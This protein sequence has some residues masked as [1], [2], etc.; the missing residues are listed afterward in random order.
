MARLI[1]NDR[2]LV[3]P[4][5][6]CRPP[7]QSESAVFYDS[8]RAAVF[9]LA[10]ALGLDK[11]ASVLLPA[12]VPEGLIAP[13]NRAGIRV[14]QYAVDRNLD[15][16][17]SHLE[18][19]LASFKPRLTTLIHYFGLRKPAHRFAELCRA[20]G[21]LMLEDLA[22]VIPC[23]ADSMFTTSGDFVLYSLP[24]IIGVPDGAVLEVGSQVVGLDR[25]P[26]GSH[27]K[28]V[29]YLAIQYAGMWCD[30]HW[31]QGPIAVGLHFLAR[32]IR[33]LFPAYPL[34]MS[35][36]HHCCPMSGVSRRL[37]E[38]V[39]W[40]D[41]AAQR[42]TLEAAY[43]A[44]LDRDAFTRFT[45]GTPSDHGKMGF[46]VIVNGDRSSFVAFLKYHQVRGVFF[47]LNWNFV[48]CGE[49]YKDADFVR[50]QHFL[51]PTR[52]SLQVSDVER[53]AR[54]A[55]EWAASALPHPS[56][57]IGLPQPAIRSAERRLS[58]RP[59]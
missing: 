51:F 18:D 19:L 45:E 8:G 16:A 13:F 52:I 56:P 5:P 37:S 48:P 26:G 36:Y 53:V 2:Q 35:Y 34:L 31:E 15:P 29:L 44:L 39:A 40:H 33:K 50:K 23:S 46:P 28:H 30:S 22:H 27:P 20:H 7:W 55:N 14:H 58:S 12:F 32:V 3:R 1:T 42:R 41:C 6:V 47:D 25:F 11:N 43:D 57:S 9:A 17:W 4:A 24:K 21:S 54:L 10:T 59:F 49:T 38:R